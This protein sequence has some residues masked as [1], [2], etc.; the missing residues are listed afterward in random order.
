MHTKAFQD[1]LM[2][3]G[4][5]LEELRTRKG[6]SSIKE[7]AVK[8]QLPVIQY[9]RMERGQANLTI[10]SLAKVLTI[11]DLTVKDFFCYMDNENKDD[12]K[13]LKRMAG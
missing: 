4:A 3:I 2:T 5:K 9:W 1:T 7:F 8:N 12:E 11:H 10:K 6:Y 13:E